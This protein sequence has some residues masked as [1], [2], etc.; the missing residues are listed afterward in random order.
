MSQYTALITGASRGIGAGIA[1]KFSQEGLN[2]ITPSRKELDLKSSKSI[3][4]YLK[5]LEQP[6]DILVNN[7]GIN[8]LSDVTEVSTNDIQDTLQ[9][10]LTA[11]L[12]LIKGVVP[13]M[14]ARRSG[15]I[16]NISSIWSLVSKAR[17]LTY[18]ASKSGLNG[19]TR[20]LAL[21]LAPYNI[22]INAVA[23]GFVDTELTR[24]NNTENEIN[25]IKETI[26]L[27]RL[28]GI[29]E[30]AEVVYFLCSPNNTYMTGQIIT[31]DGGFTCQ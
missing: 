5:T 27:Q 3:E 31:V 2:V 24:Q 28:A 8:I 22:L 16:V 30:I 12:Q 9:V 7:A 20:T 14:M 13:Q 23:P 21:E 10:N 19:L 29:S 18:A 4:S 26:P 6:I 11:P 15:K 17:R 1:E 25:K